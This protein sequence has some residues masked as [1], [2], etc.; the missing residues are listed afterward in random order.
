MPSRN[1]LL[2]AVRLALLVPLGSVVRSTTHLAAQPSS[3]AV[4]GARA[5]VP[6]SDRLIGWTAH[7]QGEGWP[8]PGWSGG[9][10]LPAPGRWARSGA[11]YVRLREA[12]EW[13]AGV[14]RIEVADLTS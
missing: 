1:L 12:P 9:A 11:H 4:I 6:G 2:A 14:R 3:R 7:R 8:A 5:M 10:Q 13:P